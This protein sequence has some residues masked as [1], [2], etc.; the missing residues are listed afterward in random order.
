MATR[1][2]CAV[3]FK[4]SPSWE[5]TKRSLRAIRKSKPQRKPNV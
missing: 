4:T 3:E 5:S 1:H 2:E